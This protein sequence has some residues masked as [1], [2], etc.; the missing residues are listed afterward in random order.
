MAG[1]LTTPQIR[2]A[3]AVFMNGTLYTM[4]ATGSASVKKGLI[5]ASWKLSDL[6]DGFSIWTVVDS[7]SSGIS[8]MFA[9]EI[10]GG[11]SLLTLSGGNYRLDRTFDYGPRGGY[12]FSYEIRTDGSTVTSTGVQYGS[13]DLPAIASTDLDL[14][15]VMYPGGPR[16]LRSS[17]TTRK[18]TKDGKKLRVHITSIYS[19]LEGSRDWTRSAR[20]QVRRS[21]VEVVDSSAKKIGLRYRTVIAGMVIPEMP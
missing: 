9:R 6:P 12:V 5:E 19:P 7:T 15:E 2:A 8:P 11:Q 16:E 21:I 4:E 13:V 14:V 17:M 20:P 3:G 1:K 18:V 10:E